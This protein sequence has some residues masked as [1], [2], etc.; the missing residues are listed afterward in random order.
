MSYGRRSLSFFLFVLATCIFQLWPVSHVGAQ[1][2]WDALFE[3]GFD[4]PEGKTNRAAACERIEKIHQ[5]K[6][7]TANR[8]AADEELL[9]K[10][11]DLDARMTSLDAGN[12][13]DLATHAEPTGIWRGVGIRGIS[14]SNSYRVSLADP[15]IG[16]WLADDQDA[17]TWLTGSQ[18]RFGDIS[19]RAFIKPMGQDTYKYISEGYFCLDEIP[20]SNVIRVLHHVVMIVC[21]DSPDGKVLPFD[22]YVPGPT[23]D[24]G[25]KLLSG[26]ARDFPHLFELIFSYFTIDVAVFPISPGPSE[27]VGIDLTV[28][29]N[30]EALQADYPSIWRLL[31]LM[32]GV[33]SADT[34]VSNQQGQIV[35]TTAFDSGKDFF[36]WRISVLNPTLTGNPGGGPENACALGRVDSGS[37]D[38]TVFQDLTIDLLGLHITAE[39]LAI[40]LKYRYKGS[41][42]FVSARLDRLPETIGAGGRAL[43]VIPVW[44]VDAL[45]PSTVE[46]IVEAFFRTLSMSD[47]G[48]GARLALGSFTNHSGKETLWIRAAADVLANGTI[49]LGFNLQSRLL[50]RQEGLLEEAAAFRNRFWTAF[51]LDF[52]LARSQG[53]CR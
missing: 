18:E 41:R 45:I 19:L 52:K 17:H 26:F 9:S 15:Q 31:R 35:A 30:R 20:F 13:Y 28:R 6:E 3:L 27:W 38:F 33:I 1:T 24:G 4:Q 34:H 51:D 5:W 44:L 42:P 37:A 50:A 25:L 47:E 22:P 43:H 53:T 36:H 12:L 10:I 49:K 16:N 29:G 39:N 46:K 2:Y 23:S 7:R 14:D 11:R 8:L 21:R 48:K 40:D 32:E